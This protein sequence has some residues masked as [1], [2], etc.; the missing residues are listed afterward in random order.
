MEQLHDSGNSV[1]ILHISGRKFMIK[2]TDSTHA[3]LTTRVLL[4]Y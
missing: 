4:H 2:F 3:N 1:N